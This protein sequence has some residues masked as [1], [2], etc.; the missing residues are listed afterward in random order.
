[1][2]RIYQIFHHQKLLH[3]IPF[4]KKKRGEKMVT[5]IER[6]G[7]AELVLLDKITIDCMTN[8]NHKQWNEN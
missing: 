8:N 6:N 1:M 5:R 2:P 4:S 7:R 3:S